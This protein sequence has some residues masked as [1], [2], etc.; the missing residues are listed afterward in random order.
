MCPTD[1][2]YSKHMLTLHCINTLETE[3]EDI[4][5][6]PPGT[7][8]ITPMGPDGKPVTLTVDIDDDI[9]ELLEQCRAKYQAEADA[10]IGDAP[11][12][13]FNHKDED[14]AGWVK[15]IYWAGDDPKTG[16][17]RAKIEW[18]NAGAAAIKGK[19]YRRFSPCF[20]LDAEGKITG[21][22]VNFGGI[23]NQAAFRT[24]QS[25]F[26]KNGENQP[27]QNQNTTM[28]PEEIAALKQQLAELTK[29]N[30]E[31]KKQLDGS[32]ETLEAMKAD[33]AKKQVDCAVSEGKIKPDPEVKAKWTKL[34]IADPSN[35]TLLA[36]LTPDP[37][38]KAV[39]PPTAGI[40]A[41]NETGDV[42]AIKAKYESLAGASRI[43]FFENH[44]E[45]LLK[46]RSGQ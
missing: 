21:A 42:A 17:V 25:F 3:P 5:L 45:T 19:S 22:P 11:Y 4:Q 6:M 30:E 2:C 32:K 26:A 9:A 29:Q 34:L 41:K 13:D 44:R 14:A 8:T 43:E 28:T 37:A 38:L 12:I 10:G 40:S 35:S 27:N 31:L 16:G 7:H 46:C 36:G 33:D 23:V 15:S 18:S 20:N 39:I 24:I 1:I